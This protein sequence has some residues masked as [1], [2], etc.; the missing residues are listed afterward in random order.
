MMI[1]AQARPSPNPLPRAGEGF[2]AGAASTASLGPARPL[3]RLRERGGVR[4]FGPTVSANAVNPHPPA[5]PSTSPS[6]RGE[7]LGMRIINGLHP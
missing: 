7:D 5:S 2:S 3:Y 1:D 6:G 4:G